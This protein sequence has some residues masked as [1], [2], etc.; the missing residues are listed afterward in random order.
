MKQKCQ[1]I[2][3]SVYLSVSVA[4]WLGMPGCTGYSSESLYREGVS[5]VYVEMFENRSFRRGIEYELTDALA[6]RIEAETPYKVVSDR[7]RADT[8][9]S[10]Q[11]VS[12]SES[13]LSGERETGRALEKEVQLEAVVNWKDLK[14]GKLLIDN[15]FVDASASFSEW[16]GQGFRY[17]SSLAANN[18]AG[19]IVELMEKEW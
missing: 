15:G 14:T 4:V 13:I 19:K 9:I 5:S 8:E 17:G 3:F 6:K 1:W 7:S 18:L 16:Q 11:I 12:A 10:G 2:L